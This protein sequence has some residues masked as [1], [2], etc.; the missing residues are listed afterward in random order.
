MTLDVLRELHRKGRQFKARKQIAK[1]WILIIISICL[2]LF[3][4]YFFANNKFV[5]G[6]VSSVIG[7]I[8]ILIFWLIRKTAY[9]YL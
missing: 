8:L 7:L 2:I 9:R 3:S 4:F 5:P 6:V 1:S